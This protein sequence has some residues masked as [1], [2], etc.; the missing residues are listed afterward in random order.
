MPSKQDYYAKNNCDS[1]IK[2]SVND[3]LNLPL[4]RVSSLPIISPLPIS[5]HNSG[6]ISLIF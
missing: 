4:T 3:D 1:P 6:K 2:I 5:T